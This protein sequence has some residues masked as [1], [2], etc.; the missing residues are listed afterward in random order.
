MRL[1]CLF[2]ILLVLATSAQAQPGALD[3]VLR[4]APPADAPEAG[5]I[6]LYAK[7]KALVIGIDAYTEKGWPKL[8][9]AYNDARA[10]ADALKEQGFEV[11]LKR[12]L[13]SDDLDRT[14]KAFFVTEGADPNARLLLWFAGHGHTVD[15]EG[16]IVPADAAGPDNDAAFRL[17]A[18]SV[19]RFSEYMRE[20]KAK[21]VLAVFDSC[22]SGT[23]FNVARSTP[24]AAIT[25]ATAMPVRQFVSS[26]EAAQEVSDDSTFRKLFL[27]ALAGKE[28]HADANGDGY[29]TGTELG[30][31]L[32]DKLTN[33]TRNKQTP[34]YGK[35][36]AFEFDRG[37]FVFE[38]GKLKMP[39][40]RPEPPLSAAAREWQDVK[41]SSNR[42]VLEAF[43]KRHQSDPVYAALAEEAIAKLAPLAP[44][45]PAPALPASP[46]PTP[47]PPTKSAAVAPPASP[48]R[49]A[50]IETVVLGTK[51]CLEP[52]NTIT[53]CEGCP[54]MVVV[55]GG[56]FMMGSPD[57][58][59]EREKDEGPQRRVTV[60]AFAVGR[61]EVTFAEWDA[62]VADG[63][64]TH[65][66][67]DEGWG[68]GRRPVIN[69]TWDDAKTYIAWIAA[70]TG[71][72]YRL[73]TEAEWEY[74]ARAGTTT[75]YAFGHSITNS[76]A[77]FSEVRVGSSGKT[78]EVGHFPANAFGLRQMHGNVWEWV[79]DCYANSYS[80]APTDGS[81]APDTI[82]CSRVRRGGS[83]LGNSPNL[84]SANRNWTPPGIRGR[85]GGFRLART[86]PT[87]P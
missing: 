48:S 68:R 46:T 38:T 70:K 78:A 83:W 35:L 86:L 41:G 11:T 20:A 58:E 45:T 25:L 14:L 7:S 3:V 87:A 81:K 13:K 12:D 84:R 54:E 30:L 16:Y 71:A 44:A 57:N 17:K 36:N 80:N 61:Y 73:L 31:F 51:R 42:A 10:V 15:G 33:Y 37:D 79:E 63:G 18:I 47:P 21:H 50:G 85:D 82:G 4:A 22:F 60:K 64:C 9:N 43:R 40:Q 24:P 67:G 34:R 1:C 39:P 69:V 19:R 59:E 62:C 53:E 66:P 76:Q 56:S 2:L 26:G 29:I 28:P 49:C 23:V 75:R 32:H 65:K 8:S 77:Q 72:P 55:P 52:G 74:A 5:R 27:D 6:R